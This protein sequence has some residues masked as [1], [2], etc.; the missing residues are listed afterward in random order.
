MESAIIHF[1]I[2]VIALDSKRQSGRQYSKCNQQIS[3]T[4][5]I[6]SGN[7]DKESILPRLDEPIVQLGDRC[8][9]QP[10][11]V[12]CTLG[13]ANKSSLACVNISHD[14]ANS[15]PRRV[16]IHAGSS[17][18]NPT[19]EQTQSS[20]EESSTSSLG[21]SVD[22]SDHDDAI[23]SLPRRR[24]AGRLTREE[25]NAMRKPAVYINRNPSSYSQAKPSPPSELRRRADVSRQH[26]APLIWP[27]YPASDSKNSSSH[28]SPS[29]K[30]SLV[31][32]RVERNVQDTS[33]S[34]TESEPEPLIHY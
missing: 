13:E 8:N 12:I 1:L 28:E 22:T 16:F 34:S 3:S 14:I 24:I 26:R 31:G 4:E 10:E 27:V 11:S 18:D 7:N 9:L 20:S 17:E 2:A 23:P 6:K 21:T 33:T 25:A 5:N 30:R 19:T 32:R 15:S 29:G